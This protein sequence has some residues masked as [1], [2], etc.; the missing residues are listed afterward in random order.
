MWIACAP[1]QAGL[2]NKPNIGSFPARGPCGNLFSRWSART[3]RRYRD[4][5]ATDGDPRRLALIQALC[6]ESAAEAAL[7]GWEQTRALLTRPAPSGC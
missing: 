4:P 7:A 3:F 5:V 2:W 6:D 1:G